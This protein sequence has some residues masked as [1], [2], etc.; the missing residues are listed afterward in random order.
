MLLL[1]ALPAQAVSIVSDLALDLE[2]WA[3][4]PILGGSRVGASIPSSA[5]AE[6]D[7]L[8][9][10]IVNGRSGVR[11]HYSHRD[12]ELT[13][14]HEVTRC[15]EATTRGCSARGEGVIQF[16]VSEPM[17]FELSGGVQV[18]DTGA[19][20]RVDLI[21]ALW[22]ITRGRLQ[23]ERL[24]DARIYSTHTPDE[25]LI[26]GLSSG[27]TGNEIEGSL[28]GLLEPVL[29][30]EAYPD[31]RYELRYW[32]GLSDRSDDPADQGAS[33]TSTITI[34]LA[35]AD[36]DPQP[37]V[38]AT[39]RDVQLV[40][41]DR[42]GRVDPGDEIEYRIRIDNIGSEP[43][44]SVRFD[45]IPDPNSSLVVGSVSTSGEVLSGNLAGD[46]RVDVDL[47]DLPV[48]AGRDLSFRV[49]VDR[50]LPEDLQSISNQ[51]RVVGENFPVV[52]TDDPD[53]AASP[54][55]T[56]SFVSNTPLDRCERDREALVLDLAT[57]RQDLD[58]V[59]ADSDADGIPD[60][61]DTCPSTGPDAPTDALGCSQRQFCARVA[62][63]HAGIPAACNRAD[64]MNDEPLGARD[65]QWRG[66]SCEP[67]VRAVERRR[68]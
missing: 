43:A 68:R 53:T 28:T 52:S 56:V 37:E 12:D 62:T 33:A 55:G 21:V 40:D 49:V 38:V 59:L 2:V 32:V 3:F 44:L 36:L 15:G 46:D 13:I 14:T 65:C 66:G 16:R 1:N 35:P 9:N 23:L 7:D 24:Y 22:S 60:L 54:D 48:G 39:K 8:T 25:E 47:G 26:L 11:A 50:T 34:R 20:D 67:R 41:L 42:D 63:E 58:L 64:W 30:N 29:P 57:C 51:G 19:G 10:E 18:A 61:F 27:D 5:L 45:D 31:R 6:G 17:T 4:D